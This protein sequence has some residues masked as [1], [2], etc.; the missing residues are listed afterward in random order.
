M[1][2]GFM[3][4]SSAFKHQ[5]IDTKKEKDTEKDKENTDINSK[6]YVTIRKLVQLIDKAIKSIQ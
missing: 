4:R 1:S 5:P 6:C 2:K 3:I